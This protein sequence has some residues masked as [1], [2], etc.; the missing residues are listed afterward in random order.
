ML[1]ELSAAVI[2][3]FLALVGLLLASAFFSGSETALFNLSRGEIHKMAAGGWAGH[4]VARLLGQPRRLLNT[5][6]L[7]NML[8]NVAY[9]ATSAV[10]VLQFQ[11]QG[12]AAWAIGAMSIAPLLVLI[13]FGEVTPKMLAYGVAREWS[14]VAASPIA[15]L[16]R[17]LSPISWVL[18]RTMVAPLTMIFAPRKI[19]PPAISADELAA[20]MRLSA[21]RGIL[22][23]TASEMLQEIV[24][25][26]EVRVA[27]VM[28]PRVEVIAFDINRPRQQLVE[29]FSQ[30][31]LRKIPVYDGQLDHVLG[32][33]HAKRVLLNHHTPLRE[34]IRPVWFVPETARLDTVLAQF[35]KRHN[36]MAIVVDEYGGTAGLVTLEDVLEE[37]V[38]NIPDRREEPLPEPVAGLGQGRYRISGDLAV[39]DWAEAFDFTLEHGRISTVGG[40]VTSLLGRL[41]RPG[42]CVSCRN[43]TFTVEAVRGRRIE[44]LTLAR[45]EDGS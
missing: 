12:L 35:R 26:N 5:L 4:L 20:L 10:L 14:L 11:E 1:A 9:S 41:A 19:A 23:A 30:T 8:V 28:A 2:G 45:Q 31:R 27:E 42:D 3:E 25:L 40:F 37:I 34:M 39:R 22:D 13:L 7:G 6:L 32:V 15:V 38:G 24:E 36:Q 43:L 21:R 16:Q 29:L 33:V 18:D 44:T 17:V